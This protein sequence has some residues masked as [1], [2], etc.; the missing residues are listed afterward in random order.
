MSLDKAGMATVV[1][2]LWRQI[3]ATLHEHLWLQLQLIWD[4]AEPARQCLRSM[5]CL[6]LDQRRQIHNEV[7]GHDLAWGLLTQTL[8]PVCHRLD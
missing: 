7:L 8:G 5:V 6:H 3:R 2:A 4:M 1:Q